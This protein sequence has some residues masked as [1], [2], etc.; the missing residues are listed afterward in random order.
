[1][2]GQSA[3]MTR[4]EV[5]AMINK[6]DCSKQKKSATGGEPVA[7]PNKFGNP[8]LGASGKTMTKN[9]EIKIGN[10]C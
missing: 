7:H 6:A 5:T 4:S 1:M 9:R 2:A 8:S 3:R 10:Y